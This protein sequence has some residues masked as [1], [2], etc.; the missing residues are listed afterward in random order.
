MEIGSWPVNPP[1]TNAPPTPPVA[2][3]E[4]LPQAQPPADTARLAPA[5]PAPSF[6]G[7]VMAAGLTSS[8]GERMGEAISS[9]DFDRQV[10]MVEQIRS[11][12][13]AGQPAGPDGERALRE[14]AHSGRDH[15]SFQLTRFESSTRYRGIG[16]AGR[17]DSNTQERGRRWNTDPEA[18][19]RFY[20]ADTRRREWAVGS[21]AGMRISGFRQD[22]RENGRS[23]RQYGGSL[24]VGVG[25]PAVGLGVSAGIE[26]AGREGSFYVRGEIPTGWGRSRGV[27]FR[28]SLDRTAL[29]R[30][31]A[32]RA[33]HAEL[34]RQLDRQ[35]EQLIRPRP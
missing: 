7:E 33:L 16:V 15:R 13:S 1:T 35:W 10:G 6:G 23:E 4:P 22:V 11:A 18:E 21:R 9:H 20:Q 34:P 3:A 2:A 27:E 29:E 5:E 26:A 19:T 25:T 17:T 24:E 14:F 31:A 32:A 12:Q 8:F 28:A 30:D